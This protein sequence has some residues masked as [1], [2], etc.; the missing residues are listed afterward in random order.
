MADIK[1]GTIEIKGLAEL[2]KRLQALPD[3][4]AKNVLTRA[5]RAGAAV[6]RDEAKR[7][8]PK[9]TGE[10]ARDIMLKKPRKGNGLEYQVYVR[11]GK[12]SRMAGK[13]RNVDRDSFYWRFV[14]FGTAKMAA[15]PFMRPA[16]EA[17][18]QEAIE[19]VRESLAANIDKELSK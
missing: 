7:I 6:F 5:L 1:T 10:M 12:K 13:K 19:K 3:K 11:S 9:D 4:L 16:F 8:A 14:E 2:E 17:K 18:R 15:K